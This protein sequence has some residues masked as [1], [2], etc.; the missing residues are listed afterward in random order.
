[1]RLYAYT[2]TR[3]DWPASI[4]FVMSKVSSD[5][6]A[7]IFPHKSKLCFMLVLSLWASLSYTLSHKYA[8]R[9]LKR[10]S[11]KRSYVCY[12]CLVASHLQICSRERACAK[13]MQPAAI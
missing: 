13:D 8:D 7:D 3:I 1:M 11:N 10:D 5:L 4:D 2:S 12:L 6:S 9:G